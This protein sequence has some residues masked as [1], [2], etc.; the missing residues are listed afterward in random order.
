MK[1][2]NQSDDN[3][4]LPI[5]LSEEE[6]DAVSSSDDYNAEHMSTNMLEYICD[7]SQSHMIINRREA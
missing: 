6:M 7:F 2:G 3:S 4:D 1:I 5:L